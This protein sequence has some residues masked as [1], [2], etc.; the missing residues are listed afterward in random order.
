[1]NKAVTIRRHFPARL[2]SLG[3]TGG[4]PW[5]SPMGLL[6]LWLLIPCPWSVP[7]RAE[8][9]VVLVVTSNADV[10]KYRAAQEAFMAALPDWRVSMLDL[11]DE[12]KAEAAIRETSSLTPGLVFAIGSKAYSLAADRWKDRPL[13]FS[14][15]LNWRRLAQTSRSHGISNEPLSRMQIYLFKS[16]LPGIRRIGVLYSREFTREWV[17]DMTVQAGEMGLEIRGAE[18]SASQTASRILPDLLASADA[19][20]LIS[21]PLVITGKAALLEILAAC[22]GR[23]IPVLSYNEAFAAAGATLVVAVDD[24][25]IGRQAAGM[26]RDILSGTPPDETVQFPAG[27]SVILNMGKVKAH[28]LEF[29][30]DALGQVNHVIE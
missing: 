29:N 12:A 17:E 4:R 16:L 13:V 24:P 20:W 2:R 21:D 22:D 9:P 30:P 10:E 1:M 3:C 25:T 19:L 15:V 8:S 6:L 14:S 27:S 18:V 11:G 23:K 26:A 5:G 28:G 7:A